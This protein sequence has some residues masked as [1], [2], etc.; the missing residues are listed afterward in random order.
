MCVGPLVQPGHALFNSQPS[1]SSVPSA[2]ARRE[3]RAAATMKV[4][5]LHPLSSSD[6]HSVRCTASP[7]YSGASCSTPVGC[8]YPW[9]PFLPRCPP[10]LLFTQGFPAQCV[11]QYFR[12][13]VGGQTD[14]SLHLRELLVLS[15]LY[16]FF[17][18]S[19]K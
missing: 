11:E 3:T 12:G 13:R 14:S 10:C 4:S 19:V 5:Y 9:L 18:S 7:G 1:V 8:C 6:P 15:E 2:G 16:L 17:S